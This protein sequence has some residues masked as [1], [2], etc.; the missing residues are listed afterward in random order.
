[1]NAFVRHTLSIRACLRQREL[2]DAAIA[3]GQ[4]LEAIRAKVE[5]APDGMKAAV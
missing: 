5:A 2:Q 1:M 3:S 4:P